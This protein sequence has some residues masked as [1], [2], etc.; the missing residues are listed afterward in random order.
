MS[1]RQKMNTRAGKKLVRRQPPSVVKPN[2]ADPAYGVT[3][4]NRV[5]RE[6]YAEEYF[7]AKLSGITVDE[8]VVNDNVPAQP[9]PVN[10][11]KYHP[12]TYWITYTGQVNAAALT[13]TITAFDIATAA[14]IEV[15][16][17]RHFA[18]R[19]AQFWVTAA[20]INT[21]LHFVSTLYVAPDPSN[22]VIAG[23]FED[24]SGGALLPRKF[25]CHFKG[26]GLVSTTADTSTRFQVG[27]SSNN[28]YV[29][30]F[31]VTAF[32]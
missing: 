3:P 12:V 22:G 24:I 2:L 21:Q 7:K 6:F 11:I 28:H 32:I 14:G 25:N 4:F 31:E 8:L 20:D 19:R 23:R 13:H 9:P 15:S 27:G 17:N 29:A 10:Q 18:I 5:W 1:P 26:E 30:R 16:P